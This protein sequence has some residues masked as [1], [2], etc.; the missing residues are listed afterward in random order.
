MRWDYA[1]L[2]IN[3]VFPGLGDIII[4]III[5]ITIII[6]IVIIIIVNV[7]LRVNTLAYPASMHLT[8]VS[9]E[10]IKV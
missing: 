10:M 1:W 9:Q 5:I 6:F 7:L 4:I 3:P 8:K 2:D